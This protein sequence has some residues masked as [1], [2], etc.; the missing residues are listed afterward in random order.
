MD[1]VAEAQDW[2]KSTEFARRFK[3][4]LPPGMIPP[5]K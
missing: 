5:T 1:L 3:M 2:P 4:L